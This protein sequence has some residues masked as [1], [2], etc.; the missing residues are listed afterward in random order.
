[1]AAFREFR[2]LQY[3]GQHGGMGKAVNRPNVNAEMQR[4]IC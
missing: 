1:M 4:Q 2:A 3:G